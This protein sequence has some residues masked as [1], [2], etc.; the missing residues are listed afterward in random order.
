MKWKKEDLEKYVQA[1]EYIDTILLPLTPFQIGDDAAAAKTAFQ[2]EAMHIFIHEME[3]ELSGRM[4][5]AP[6][7]YYLKATKEEANRI[8]NWIEDMQQQ[9]FEH[10]ILFTF[11]TGWKKIEKELHGNVLWL[12]GVQT[13]DLH[14][15]EMQTMIRDQ[16]TQISE[17]I[18]SYW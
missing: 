7:Y 13:G 2:N 5:L 8:N 18:R 1:K 10:I 3:K 16:I 9:P 6:N 12:P 14:A 4:M 15:K 11:D 17:M